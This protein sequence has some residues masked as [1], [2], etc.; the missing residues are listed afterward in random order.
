M[1]PTD[2]VSVVAVGAL[3]GYAGTRAMEPVSMKLY[4]LESEADRQQ[5]DRVRPGPPYEIAAQKS[6]RLIGRQLTP[7]QI[8]QAGLAFHYALG[9][10]WG[11]VYVLLRRVM[12]LNPLAA[13]LLT[14][15]SLSLLVD[16]GLT[17]LLGFSAPNRAYPLATHIRGFIAHLVYGLG[18]A[19]AA[20]GVAFVGR[21]ALPD[22][23]V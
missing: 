5:E 11:L 17:P 15:A 7:D 9:L 18:V 14:G 3:A 6:A 2:L 1:T 10:S 22:L 16:E 4:E 19:A 8:K 13:G 12:R 20:E 21:N 23:D